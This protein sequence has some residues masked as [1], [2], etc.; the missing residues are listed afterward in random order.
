MFLFDLMLT[1]IFTYNLQ[2]FPISRYPLFIMR[3]KSSII[4]PESP[5]QAKKFLQTNEEIIYIGTAKESFGMIEKERWVSLTDNGR[6]LIMQSSRT[7]SLT[8]S[9]TMQRPPDLGE[10]STSAS[11]SPLKTKSKLSSPVSPTYAVTKS[12]NIMKMDNDNTFTSPNSKRKSFMYIQDSKP[13]KTLKSSNSSALNNLSS[14]RMSFTVGR[15]E[16]PVKLQSIGLSSSTSLEI[17]QLDLLDVII[18]DNNCAIT[19]SDG[20]LIVKRF[21]QRYKFHD[22][23][24]D[25]WLQRL[26]MMR[27]LNK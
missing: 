11:N 17:P 26:E 3:Y 12:E 27:S 23:P 25:L 10:L 15:K 9:A 1:K 18:I 7:R 5:E 22:I 6:F 4:T 8:A 20:K 21:D 13:N 14:V 24:C 16:N 2:T 19:M